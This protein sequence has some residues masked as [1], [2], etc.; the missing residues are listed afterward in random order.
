MSVQWRTRVVIE[1][2]APLSEKPFF[3]GKHVVISRN[4]LRGVG[5]HLKLTT[6]VH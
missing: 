2:H 6:C 3:V 4:E 5:A 1:L